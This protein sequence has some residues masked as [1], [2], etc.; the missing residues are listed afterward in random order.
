MAHLHLVSADIGGDQPCIFH[1]Q[2]EQP[3]GRLARLDLSV[4]RKLIDGGT[5]DIARMFSAAR[6]ELV[7][8]LLRGLIEANHLD[9][10]LVPVA[11]QPL[12]NSTVTLDLRR[13]RVA[14]QA[15]NDDRLRRS[16]TGRGTS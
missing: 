2:I 10:S 4:P 3:D 8:T 5:P 11:T 15:A 9:D 14:N 1:F 13:N 12:P 16:G 7:S 6:T